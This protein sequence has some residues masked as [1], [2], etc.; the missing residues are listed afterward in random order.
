MSKEKNETIL[1]FCAHNDDGVIGAGGTLTKYAQEGKTIKTVV[2]SFGEQSHPHIKPHIIKLKRYEEA[3]KA[4]KIM[5]GGGIAFLDLREMR[6]R[7]DAQQ[8]GTDELIKEIILNE[9]PR[10]IFTHSIND[11][12]PDHRAVHKLILDV[13]RT[14]DLPL[15]VYEFDVW[16]ILNIF[17]RDFPKLVVDVSDTFATKIKA[18]KAHSSQKGALVALTWKLYIQAIAH[19]LTFGYTYAEVFSRVR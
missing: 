6:L 17:H 16:N 13:V 1:V 7:A 5:G 15:E 3:L 8:K 12:M 10:K 18:F 2:F 4:D 14:I 19:G 9:K 11:P